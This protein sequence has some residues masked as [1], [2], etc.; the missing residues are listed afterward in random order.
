MISELTSTSWT[1]LAIRRHYTLKWLTMKHYTMKSDWKVTLHIINAWKAVY[2]PFGL[3]NVSLRR[4][5]AKVSGNEQE[6]MPIQ[7]ANR[8]VV[9]KMKS[10]SNRQSSLQFTR[11]CISI[12][13]CLAVIVSGFCYSIQCFS[14]T[15]HGQLNFYTCNTAYLS[16]I[17]IGL[18]STKKFTV[19]RESAVLGYCSILTLSTDQ[20]LTQQMRYVQSD[21]V[22]IGCVM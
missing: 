9:E 15:Q 10:V 14:A 1:F 5:M 12:V 6:A 13:S 3:T 19:V 17:T 21:I 4:L 2:N 18:A 20:S 8:G 11:R 16:L 22:Y 7:V